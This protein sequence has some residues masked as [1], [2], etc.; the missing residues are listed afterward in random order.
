MEG[1][2]VTEDPLKQSDTQPKNLNSSF[3]FLKCTRCSSSDQIKPFKHHHNLF[4]LAQYGDF[5]KFF[6][7]NLKKFSRR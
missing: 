5:M 3:T 7:K 6:P 1:M 4:S 2:Y